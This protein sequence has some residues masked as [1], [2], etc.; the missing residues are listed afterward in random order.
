MVGIWHWHISTFIITDISPP[1]WHFVMVGICRQAMVI[2][3]LME[4]TML[5]LMILTLP[6]PCAAKER[7]GGPQFPPRK[8]T[9]AA[10]WP[11]MITMIML[12]VFNN[13]AEKDKKR[14]GENVKG[15]FFG[16]WGVQGNILRIFFNNSCMK[17]WNGLGWIGLEHYSLSR[18]LSH[19]GVQLG[20]LSIWASLARRFYSMIASGLKINSHDRWCW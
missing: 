16:L 6:M 10:F 15:T 14:H 17:R 11:A 20:N 9:D 13:F 19:V 7:R 1:W 12:S 8:W 4:M 18:V 5:L 3:T 2:R